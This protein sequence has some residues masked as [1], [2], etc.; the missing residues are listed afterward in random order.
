MVEVTKHYRDEHGNH[1]G[2]FVFSG[3][4]QHPD[5]PAGA[6]ECPAPPSGKAKW[7]NGEWEYTPPYAPLRMR[8]YEEAGVTD[9]SRLDALWDAIM[10]VDTTKA[11]ALKVARDAVRAEPN[12]PVKAI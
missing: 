3:V 10:E 8:M 11:D 6:I 2:A 1:I 5:V 7:V 4:G 9:A 12:F